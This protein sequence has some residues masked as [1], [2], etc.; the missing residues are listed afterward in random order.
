MS[1]HIALKSATFFL[2]SVLLQEI[3]G[4]IGLVHDMSLANLG[5][6]GN[7]MLL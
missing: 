1:K 5:F 6:T 4:G 3:R 7:E 2:A